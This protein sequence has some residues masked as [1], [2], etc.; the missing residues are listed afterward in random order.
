MKV[1]PGKP[2]PLGAVWDG[3]GTNFSLFSEA[4]ERVQLCLFDDSG[5]EEDRIELPVR[6]AF[7]WHGFLPDVGPGRRYGF[8]VEGP[9]A[10]EEGHRCDA[11]K[12]LLDPYAKAIEGRV[13]WDEAVFTHRFDAPESERNRADSAGRMPRCVVI[14][15]S[16][17]WEEDRPP[18]TPLHET[19]IYEVHVKGFTARHPDVPK[20]LRGTY[21]GLAHPAALSHLKDL[22]ITAVELMPVQQFVHAKHLL[23]R[24]LRNYWGYDSIGFFAPHNEYSSSGEAG[25]QVREFQQMV[26]ALH[27]EGIEVI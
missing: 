10:P 20:P 19:I 22:G 3:Q 2:Y 13:D 27:R 16:F 26:K 4:A 18:S 9:W 1:W 7:C 5:E 14:D 17:D 6:D 25:Q 24:G 12:L 11:S 21:A 8:R 23:D 15:P